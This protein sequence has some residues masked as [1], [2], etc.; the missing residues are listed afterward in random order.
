MG[1]ICG[2]NER[3]CIQ[4]LVGKLEGKRWGM[5]GKIISE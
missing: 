1:R 3:E 5:T 4:D 2:V